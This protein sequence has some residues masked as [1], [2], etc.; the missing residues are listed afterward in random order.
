[1]RDLVFF[2]GTLMAG[3]DRRRRAGIDNKLTY[4]GRGS[5]QGSLFD[6]GSTRR[7]PGAG[8][9]CLGRGLRDDRA[10]DGARRARRDRR[11]PHDD[12]DKSLYRRQQ[13]DVGCRTA[14]APG[15]GLF[16]QRAL[17]R[18]PRIASGDYLEHT[19]ASLSDEVQR[20]LKVLK[21]L[22][23]LR[24]V[25]LLVLMGPG[26]ALRAQAPAAERFDPRIQKLV[27]SVSEERL[28]QLLQKLSSYKTRNSCS[29]PSAP[30][31][32]GAARQWIL[33]ELK[34]TSPK[35][36]VSF[37]THLVQTVRGCAGTDRVPQR[38]GSAARQERAPDSTSAATTT[39]STSGA[40]A[41]RRVM[42]A[43]VPRRTRPG[44][45]PQAPG[46][47]PGH[48]PGAGAAAHPRSQ[49]SGPRGERTTGAGRCCRWSWRAS[50]RESV[51]RVRRDAR[52]HD[53]AG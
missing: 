45:A 19:K 41:S 34:R 14:A 3:F 12:P 13:A 47:A 26:A 18:A 15:V 29:D 5:I 7:G 23:V 10:G 30:D 42:R 27:A 6:L 28:Q 39:P 53:V 2:Y 16:L 35:L 20:V 52:L 24:V 11:L 25:V 36:Q 32:V 31:G 51:D 43:P 33:D 44:A 21:V 38:H 37:D 4:I 1:V 9:P 17:G 40:A 22:R 46:E 48:R 49:H 50:S 8:R